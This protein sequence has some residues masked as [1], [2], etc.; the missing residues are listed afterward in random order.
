MS[1]D[2]AIEYRHN[3]LFVQH[4][5][6]FNLTSSGMNEFW[7][8]IAP[9]CKSLGCK[10]VLW[11]GRITSRRM[12]TTEIYSSASIAGRVAVGLKLAC[13]LDGYIADERTFF[14]KSVA[15]RTG[16]TIDFFSTAEEALIWLGITPV[17]NI[18]LQPIGLIL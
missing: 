1:S 17:P 8:A 16:A 6:D 12:T 10:R 2:F 14:F 4:S 18:E 13:V 15:S 11:E 5:T 3:Y 7:L 9:A